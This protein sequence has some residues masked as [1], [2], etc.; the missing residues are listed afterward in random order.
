MERVQGTH[1]AIKTI[2]ALGRGQVSQQQKAVSAREHFKDGAALCISDLFRLTPSLLG[3]FV[4]SFVDVCMIFWSYFV[5][6][7]SVSHRVLRMQLISS[8]L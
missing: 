7:M 5:N 2:V 1:G 3:I 8:M 4:A 6:E